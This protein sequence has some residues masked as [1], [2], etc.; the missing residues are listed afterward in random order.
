[1]QLASCMLNEN[2]LVTTCIGIQGMKV[3]LQASASCFEFLTAVTSCIMH[4]SK[5]LSIQSEPSNS[6]T[7]R[8]TS[9]VSTRSHSI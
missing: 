4:L 9:N 8:T 3:L 7:N 1:M 5:T 2:T 6:I